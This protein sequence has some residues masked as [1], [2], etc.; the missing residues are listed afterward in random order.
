MSVEFVSE[1]GDDLVGTKSTLTERML[2]A[3]SSSLSMTDAGA[4]LA[5]HG[6]RGRLVAP[7]KSRAKYRVRRRAAPRTAPRRDRDATP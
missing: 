2:Y 5:V 7:L 6:V 3:M 4:E 1:S